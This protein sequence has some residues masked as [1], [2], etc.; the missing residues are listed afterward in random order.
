MP[1]APQRLQ[2]PSS[3]NNA[4][5]KLFDSIVASCDARHFRN[6]DI[7]L[8]VSFVQASLLSHRLGRKGDIGD[9]ERVTRTQASLATRLRLTPASRTDPKTLAR[10][11]PP[12]LR[13]W[14][15]EI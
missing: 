4:E 3:L 2:T 6:S 8:L 13:A 9:W 14:E 12:A 11:T 10:Q 7:A 5:R 15:T 1:G